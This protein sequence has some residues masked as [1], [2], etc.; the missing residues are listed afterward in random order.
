MDRKRAIPIALTAIILLWLGTKVEW[1]GVATHMREARPAP[2]ALACLLTLYFPLLSAVRW[3]AVL[4][5]TGARVPLRKCLVLVM[6]SW[7][8]GTLTPAKA[9][10]F[11]KPMGISSRVPLDVGIGT[12]LAERVVD[13]GVLGAYALLSGALA[14]IP[15]ALLLGALAL[16]AAVFAFPGAQLAAMLLPA[17]KDGLARKLRALLYVLPRL[18]RKPRM[19]ALCIGASALNWWLSM[20]QLALLLEAFRA[21]VPMVPVMAVLPVATFAG[22]LPV[23][24][25]G[26]GTRDAV[27]IALVPGASDAAVFAAGAVYTLTGYFALGALGLPFLRHLRPNGPRKD[28]A[29]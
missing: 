5:G 12:V 17:R 9:G 26:A 20:A 8:I 28:K 19:L 13:V 23:T 25:A 24:I 14:E 7:P 10:D 4:R 16:G 15:V 22:L 18:A 3:W 11:V 6:A 29:P 27:L 2:L 1:R 21:P